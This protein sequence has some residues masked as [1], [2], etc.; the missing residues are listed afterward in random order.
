MNLPA[1][2][3]DA[4]RRASAEILCGG[5]FV[6]FGLSFAVIALTYDVGTPF[7]MGPGFFPLMLG[8][9][10]TLL[11][12]LIMGSGFTKHEDSPIGI[13]PWRALVL[14]PSAF[15]F[16]GLTVRGLGVVPALFVTTLLAAFASE[17]TSVISG[18]A[19]AGGL[20]IASVLIFIV[21]LQLRLPLFGPWLSFLGL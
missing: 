8:G 2:K 16:F 12:V 6:A 17:R 19:I 7:Q 10:L 20:T 14:L 11:G 21:G 5:I 18:I 9:L 1:D 15:I 4:L 3:R 13:V